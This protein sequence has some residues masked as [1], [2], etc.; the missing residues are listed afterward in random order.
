MEKKFLKHRIN[1][2]QMRQGQSIYSRPTLEN[3][4]MFESNCIKIYNLNTSKASHDVNLHLKK[5]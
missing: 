3:Y 1:I 4:C 2:R 5:S